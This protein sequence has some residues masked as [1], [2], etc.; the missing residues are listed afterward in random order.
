LIVRQHRA[1]RKIHGVGIPVAKVARET[2]LLAMPLRPCARQGAAN[3]TA[4]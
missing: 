1:A 4:Q 2:R 3:S